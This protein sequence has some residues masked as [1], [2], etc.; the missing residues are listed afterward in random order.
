MSEGNLAQL[1]VSLT[2]VLVI[3]HVLGQL[4][5]RLHQPRVAGELLGGLLLGPTVLGFFAPDLT[6]RL[7]PAVGPVSTVLGGAEQLGML[8][9]MFLAGTEVRRLFPQGNRKAVTMVVVVGMIIPFAATLLGLNLFEIN[10]V[11]G[12]AENRSALILVIASAVAVT[13]I[14]VI[15]RIMLD[16]GILNTAFAGV[17]LSVAVIEDVVLYVVI[18]VALGLANDSER[19]MVGLPELVGMSPGIGMGFYYVVATLLFLFA[20]AVLLPRAANPMMKRIVVANISPFGATTLCAV[21]TTAMAATASLVGVQPMFGA[22]VAGILIARL[23]SENQVTL[24]AQYR[25]FASAFFLPLY[26]AAVGLELDLVNNLALGFT[27]TLFV[28][29][30]GVKL[31]SAYLGGRLGG[32]RRTPALH[33]AVALNARG[34]PGIVLANLSF[35][36]GIV[37]AEGFTAL[38]ILAVGTSLLAGG[39][40]RLALER[41]SP[42]EDPPLRSQRSGLDQAG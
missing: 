40:L 21:L 8:M 27:A 36:S 16:L 18:S 41:G 2:L 38:I 14:P 22:F 24:S 33:L 30:S 20:A 42:L 11:S 15:S 31:V 12:P 6:H 4:A 28:L 26:F 10:S 25:S 19:S 37:N 35:D 7:I 29:A 17:V 34:G 9:L 1:L 23:E 5:Q 32:K 3:A 13:S 39:W